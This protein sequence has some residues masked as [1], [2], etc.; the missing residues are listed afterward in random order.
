MKC[1][2]H[3][4]PGSKAR[5][6]DRSPAAVAVLS[7]TRH[8]HWLTSSH[9]IHL[10]HKTKV[11]PEMKTNIQSHHL[12]VSGP[13]TPACVHQKKGSNPNSCL[14]SPFTSRVSGVQSQD[15]ETQQPLAHRQQP[16]MEST[17][18]TPAACARWPGRAC[19]SPKLTF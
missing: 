9:R 3:D 5:A 13:F 7:H 15:L 16:S 18:P 17:Y 1:D 12:L 10:M 2:C 11:H 19:C 4:I 14:A 8:S 6:L